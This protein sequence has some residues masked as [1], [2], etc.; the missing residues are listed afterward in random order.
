MWCSGMYQTIAFME[1][2]WMIFDTIV[3]PV[4]KSVG[5]IMTEL[6]LRFVAA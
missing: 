3:A 4:E 6:A 5:E 1:I 2:W